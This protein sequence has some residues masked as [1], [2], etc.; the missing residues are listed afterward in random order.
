[1]RKSDIVFDALAQ[2]FAGFGEIIF[3]E[4]DG[5]MPAIQV[6][7]IFLNGCAAIFL[8]ALSMASWG[9]VAFFKYSIVMEYFLSK[10]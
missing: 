4:H 5:A 6:T 8:V 1:M 2:C 9:G 3:A 7:R 10:N